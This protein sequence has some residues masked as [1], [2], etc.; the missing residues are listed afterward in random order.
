MAAAVTPRPVSAS[1]GAPADVPAQLL[2][3]ALIKLH[4]AVGRL[5]KQGPFRAYVQ[6]AS[7]EDLAGP[8]DE[9]ALPER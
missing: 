7:L 6:G 3:L 8:P 5:Q 2:H 1:H 4:Q 9:H